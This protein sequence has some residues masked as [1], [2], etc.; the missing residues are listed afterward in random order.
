M[1]H[2]K[3]INKCTL[4]LVADA[5]GKVKLADQCPSHQASKLE[6]K[7]RKLL[8]EDDKVVEVMVLRHAHVRFHRTV[9]RATP[10]KEEAAADQA[11]LPQARQRA[12][13]LEKVAEGASAAAAQAQKESRAAHAKASK[14]AA[15]AKQAKA[16]EQ[17]AAQEEA[18]QAALAA[19]AADKIT[20]Q[21]AHNA[22]LAQPNLDHAP[23][24]GERGEK[25]AAAAEKGAAAADKEAAAALAKAKQEAEHHATVLA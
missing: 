5:K 2:Q 22:D 9:H 7:A 13:E 19:E 15:A 21:A 17:P 23:K 18:R 20:A 16:G 1:A 10:S 3:T 24:S 4:L 11:N 12:A 14:L 25:A 8:A 6:A